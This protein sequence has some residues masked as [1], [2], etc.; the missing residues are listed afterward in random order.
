MSSFANVT[1]V[2]LAA[3]QGTRMGSDQ[4]KV[5]HHVGGKPMVGHVLDTCQE[6]GIGQ[7]VVVVGHQRETVEACVAPYAA[8]CVVQDQ[9]L[10]TG[11]AVL[12]TQAAVRGNT[13]LVLCGDAP[14]VPVDLLRQVLQQRQDSGVPCVAVAADMADPSGYGR[15]LTDAS[16][17]LS[18]IV[19]HK[20]ASDEQRAVTLVNSG[21][22]AFDTAA[23]FHCLQAVRPDNAQGE[24]YLPDVVKMLVDKGQRVE[25]VTTSD[26]ASVFGVNR[27]A[28][29]AAAETMY[30]QRLS[31]A[32]Q[33]EAS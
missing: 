12:V 30:L 16:G 26:I 2:I 25:L 20:D 11:H 13:T 31:N 1:A 29:L 19:E 5:L 28:D 23:L 7:C 33:S 21:I 14:L 9:Q 10:G 8:D 4:A 22:F 3:G 17:A 32:D 18:A 15:M 6:L 24:Y 27:P